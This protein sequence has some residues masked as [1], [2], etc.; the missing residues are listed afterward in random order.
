L[1]QPDASISENQILFPGQPR[2]NEGPVFRQPWEAQAFA[3]A[4][5]LNKSGL[6]TWTQWT[7][8]IGALIAA[9]KCPDSTG[10]RYYEYWLSALEQLVAA[11]T[12]ISSDLLKTRKSAWDRAARATPHGEVIELGRDK[13]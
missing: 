4:V 9:D 7:E 5:S 13:M 8:T 3:M 12:Q 10:E 6:F 11:N 2:D 1:N